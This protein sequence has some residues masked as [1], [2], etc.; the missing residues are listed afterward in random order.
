MEFE[1]EGVKNKHTACRIL[2]GQ[3]NLEFK[4]KDGGIEESFGVEVTKLLQFPSEVI[5]DAE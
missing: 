4:I 5:I 2:D 3:I 1:V